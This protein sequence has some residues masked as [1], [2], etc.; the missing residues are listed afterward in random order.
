MARKFIIPLLLIFG[1]VILLLTLSILVQSRLPEP[2]G[3]FSV[4][5]TSMTLTDSSRPEVM[6]GDP[7]DWRFIGAI[8]WYPAQANAGQSVP[9]FPGLNQ[10]R[11]ELV[12]SGS[13]S[14]L[15]VAGLG[16]AQANS[17]WQAAVAE[18]SAPYPVLLLSPGNET[19]VVFYSALAEELASQGFVVV[20]INHPYDVPAVVLDDGQVAQ[21]DRSQWDLTPQQHQ[22][23][24]QER[25]EVRVADL[26]FVMDSLSDWNRDDLLL[27][28]R[29]DLERVGV[30]GHS[31]GGITAAQSCHS[32]ERFKAC[33]NLDGIQAGG[34]FSVYENPPLP[35]QSFMFIT[36][37]EE[38]HPRTM[39]QF[40]ALPGKGYLV[41]LQ[42]AT[43][44]SF[45][46]GPLMIPGVLPLENQADR[47]LAQT[48]KYTVAF[49]RQELIGEQS[50]LLEK[51]YQD[52]IV[53]LEV[54]P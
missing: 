48:R 53:K 47:I 12:E 19:N 27:A 2:T 42:R 8:I 36:K 23:Y 35:G 24:T 32:D 18:G 45:T 30:L 25:M 17:N 9:Y 31:L 41:Q 22:K 21:Y 3:A 51:N 5:R 4:G 43:H 29:L 34:P 52:E 15:E 20:G 38:L 54:V 40:E 13:M 10:V 33:L 28:N 7:D 44:D 16:L 46:D 11:A 49:F 50:S 26:L 39:A 14:A 6:T 37:E 1:V